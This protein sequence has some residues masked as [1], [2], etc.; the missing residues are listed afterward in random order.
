M[1]L[2]IFLNIILFWHYKTCFYIV[3]AMFWMVIVVIEKYTNSYNT[4]LAMLMCNGKM[5]L[6]S[7]VIYY[8][9]IGGLYKL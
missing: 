6:N 3:I 7:Q 8:T 5:V 2:H 9:F 1:H 4:N